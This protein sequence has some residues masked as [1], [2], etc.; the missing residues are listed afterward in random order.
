MFLNK[1][2]AGFINENLKNKH[3]FSIFLAEEN[4]LQKIAKTVK[5]KEKA[6]GKKYP[7]FSLSQCKILYNYY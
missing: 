1:N 3:I 4:H 5:Q 6:L 7:V 2:K